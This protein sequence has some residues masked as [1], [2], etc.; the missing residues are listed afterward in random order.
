MEWLRAVPA[1]DLTS[2]PHHPSVKR[3]VDPWKR[4]GYLGLV[5]AV[6]QDDI[7]DPRSG[8]S[9]FFTDINMAD[10][11]RTGRQVLTIML[12]EFLAAAI[13]GTL[14]HRDRLQERGIKDEPKLLWFQRGAQQI[15]ANFM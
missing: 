4:E 10:R 7:N 11:T 13:T 14:P 9:S 1:L 12:P 2:E 15:Y 5:D 3:Y 8:F 6:V